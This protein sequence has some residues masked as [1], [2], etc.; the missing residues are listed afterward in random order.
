ML[1]LSNPLCYHRK[2]I[3]SLLHSKNITNSYF[4]KSS[5]TSIFFLFYQKN[6]KFWLNCLGTFEKEKKHSSS[7]SQKNTRRTLCRLTAWT[8]WSVTVVVLRWKYFKS[9]FKVLILR[10]QYRDCVRWEKANCAL[11]YLVRPSFTS[12]LLEKLKQN[13]SF[14]WDSCVAPLKI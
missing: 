9:Y 7:S 6:E 11:A 12:L 1:D 13:V 2:I 10:V 14:L 3:S 5:G 8:R 4:N